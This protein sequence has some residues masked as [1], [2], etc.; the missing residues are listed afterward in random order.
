[1][2]LHNPRHLM[3]MMMSSNCCCD[4]PGPFMF[5][6]LFDCA[7]YSLEDIVLFVALFLAV[8]HICFYYTSKPECA[9]PDDNVF[10]A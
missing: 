8:S 5:S 3:T 9:I 10:P 2:Q 1:V 4:C 7:H 6:D